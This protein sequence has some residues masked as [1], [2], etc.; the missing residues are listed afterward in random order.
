MHV[1]LLSSEQSLF[2][3][4]QETPGYNSV[5]EFRVLWFRRCSF[6]CGSSRTDVYKDVKA[7]SLRSGVNSH[8]KIRLSLGFRV[9]VIPSW[10]LNPLFY[11]VQYLLDQ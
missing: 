9:S 4:A 1:F 2:D 3:A 8:E 10:Q 11:F 5:L 6:A 7:L